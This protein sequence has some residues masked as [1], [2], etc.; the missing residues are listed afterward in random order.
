MKMVFSASAA[1][2]YSGLPCFGWSCSVNHTCGTHLQRQQGRR[3]LFLVSRPTTG[4]VQRA[5]CQVHACTKKE[6]CR[7]APVGSQKGSPTQQQMG[8]LS[9]GPLS[10]QPPGC[11]LLLTFLFWLFGAL[12]RDQQSNESSRARL[13]LPEP[14]LFVIL[15]LR[16][17]CACVP[18]CVPRAC[19]ASS[20]EGF[21]TLPRHTVC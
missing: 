17:L 18:M 7:T 20:G 8:R 1:V 4:L 21:T 13:I 11:A 14:C 5:M 2:C 19:R 6:T 9:F 10:S 12:R 3:E 15:L 16:S